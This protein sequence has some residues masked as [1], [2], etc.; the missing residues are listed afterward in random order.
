[1]ND[2][3]IVIDENEEENT[4]EKQRRERLDKIRKPKKKLDGFSILTKTVMGL[5]LV[6]MFLSMLWQSGLLIGISIAMIIF[7][8]LISYV[9]FK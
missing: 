1:M 2:E 7:S 8:G 5:G 6:L 3:V 4:E 9:F